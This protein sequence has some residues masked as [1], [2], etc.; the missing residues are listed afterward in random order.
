MSADLLSLHCNYP[1]VC[2]GTTAVASNCCKT[3]YEEQQ[4]EQPSAVVAVDPSPP[5][6]SLSKPQTRE[7]GE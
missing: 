3:Y 7:P 6:S 2:E 1:D 5:T 4:Q